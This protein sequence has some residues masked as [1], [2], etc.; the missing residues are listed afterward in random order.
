MHGVIDKLVK[1]R[2][3]TVH[4]IIKVPTLVLKIYLGDSIKKYN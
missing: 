2:N 1:Q 4:Q 3:R